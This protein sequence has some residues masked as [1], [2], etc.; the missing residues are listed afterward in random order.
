[1]SYHGNTGLKL[2][3]GLGRKAVKV[4]QGTS[5]LFSFLKTIGEEPDQASCG[6]SAALEDFSIGKLHAAHPG[7]NLIKI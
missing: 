6:I 4:I 7:R 1:M 2:K 3:L 5:S